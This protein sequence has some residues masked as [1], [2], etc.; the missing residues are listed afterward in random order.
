M[1]CCLSSAGILE[2][3]TILPQVDSTHQGIGPNRFLTRRVKRWL[4]Q[5]LFMF[6]IILVFFWMRVVFQDGYLLFSYFA[7]YR[8]LSLGC[9]CLA[10][11]SWAGDW[12]DLLPKRSVSC[13]WR[14]DYSLTHSLCGKKFKMYKR[15]INGFICSKI[16]NKWRFSLFVYAINL[17]LRLMYVIQ[18]GM[19]LYLRCAVVQSV[20]CC[21]WI[22]AINS[23]T[24]IMC[25]LRA[26]L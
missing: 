9:S 17:I 11:S 20:Y 6:C 14:W 24:N 19:S 13:W 10:V 26:F 3:Q 1:F 4:S 23:L 7:F 5:A 21:F 16:C 15:F 12:R 8:G 25:C 22:W 18:C 2:L